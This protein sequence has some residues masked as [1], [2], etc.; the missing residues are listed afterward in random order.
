MDIRDGDRAAIFGDIAMDAPEG[1]PGE[2]L[3]DEFRELIA[4]AGPNVT[5][6]D[7]QFWVEL[8]EARARLVAEVFK[9]NGARFVSLSAVPADGGEAVLYYHFDLDGC[10]YSLSLTTVGR[11]VASIVE[12]F[13]GANWAERE[14]FAAYGIHFEGHPDLRPLLA[15]LVDAPQPAATPEMQLAADPRR[16]SS[17]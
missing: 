16:A 14:A 11:I 12:L 4:A 5:S 2:I 13:P 6:R 10:V 17:Q 1:S 9:R 7:G 3:A 8:T 15:G